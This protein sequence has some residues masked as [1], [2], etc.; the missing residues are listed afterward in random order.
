V[1]FPSNYFCAGSQKTESKYI[2]LRAN[3]ILRIIITS[4]EFVTGPEA[5][6]LGMNGNEA[7]QEGYC[8]G[9]RG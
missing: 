7:Y 8:T 2:S 9:V 5:G 1:T 3:V 6:D 4:G